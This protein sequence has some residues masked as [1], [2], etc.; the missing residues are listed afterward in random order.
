MN[1]NKKEDVRT[2]ANEILTVDGKKYLKV[3]DKAVLID[4][5]DEDDKPV[6]KGVY[7]EKLIGPDGSKS[8]TVHIPYLQIEGSVTGKKQ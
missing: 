2:M 1:L 7:S 5:F 6:I 3:G 4:H 8:R